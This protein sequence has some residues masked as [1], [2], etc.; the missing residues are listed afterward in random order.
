MASP[1]RSQ[2]SAVWPSSQTAWARAQVWARGA[3]FGLGWTAAS[4]LTAKRRSG[5]IRR[6]ATIAGSSAAAAPCGASADAATTVAAPLARAAA[7]TSTLGRAA[8]VTWSPSGVVIFCGSEP[9]RGPA[10]LPLLVVS[11]SMMVRANA[12]P[13]GPAPSGTAT[14]AIPST[15]TRCGAGL[16]SRSFRSAL[17]VPSTPKPA[18]VTNV[19]P[20]SDA[21]F[22][23]SNT[24]RAA[25]GSLPT[26]A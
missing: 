12:S 7:S 13:S 24:A 15:R 14:D 25:G 26:S 19:L 11:P 22:S 4:R 20:C 23:A 8:V 16:P 10:R 6:A 9:I 5:P 18:L 21:R 17:S 1:A 3:G 2:H